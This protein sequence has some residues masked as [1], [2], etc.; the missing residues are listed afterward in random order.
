M[1]RILDREDHTYESVSKTDL[2]V[3]GSR[4]YKQQWAN[5]DKKYGQIYLA[6]TITS[7]AS[8]GLAV[9]LAFKNNWANAFAFL[10][11]VA[12]IVRWICLIETMAQKK[13]WCRKKKQKIIFK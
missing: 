5:T 10:S 7:T 13:E 4:F 3:F 6:H 9:G 12:T 2:K 8:M 1:E 11:V